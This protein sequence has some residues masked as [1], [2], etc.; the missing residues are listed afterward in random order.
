M[1]SFRFGCA[2]PYASATGRRTASTQTVSLLVSWLELELGWPVL[3]AAIRTTPST[4]RGAS[5]DRGTRR[6]KD[7]GGAGP[8]NSLIP[9]LSAH[10]RCGAAAG[11]TGRALVGEAATPAGAWEP[12]V[13]TCNNSGKILTRSIY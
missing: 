10:D 4:A 3:Q 2:L 13:A 9:L 11:T 5:A 1:S 6:N 7:R 12:L 8:Q